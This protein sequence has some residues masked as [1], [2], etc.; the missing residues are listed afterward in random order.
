M[1]VPHMTKR[2]SARTRLLLAFMVSAPTLLAVSYLVQNGF[3]RIGLAL[4]LLIFIVDFL[5][6]KPRLA[7]AAASSSAKAP[8]PSRSIWVVGIACFSGSLSLLL[9]GIRE[10]NTWEIAGASLGILACGWGVSF[11]R[12]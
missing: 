5:V 9:S 6:V 11:A 2:L 4:F 1:D 8:V 10:R 3:R 7:N 12:R